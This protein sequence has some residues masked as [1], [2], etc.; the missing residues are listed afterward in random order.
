[1]LYWLRNV[2]DEVNRV[3]LS[4][5]T[6]NIDPSCVDG[7]R[8][9]LYASTMKIIFTVDTYT[10]FKSQYCLAHRFRHLQSLNV[11]FVFTQQY[12]GRDR[13]LQIL[14]DDGFRF[15]ILDTTVV[16]SLNSRSPRL[17]FRLVNRALPPVWPGLHIISL[18][19]K[20][21]SMLE[22]E[23]PDAVVLPAQNRF[24]QPLLASE[25]M[26][27]GVPVVVCPLWMAGP[28]EQFEALRSNAAQRLDKF[29]NRLVALLFPAWVSECH[30]SN[31]RFLALPWSEVLARQLLG[32]HVDRPWT[33]HSGDSDVICVESVRMRTLGLGSGLDASKLRIT[34][35]VFH[36]MMLESSPEFE[37]RRMLVSGKQFIEVLTALPPDMFSSRA[38]FCVDFSTYEDL[39]FNWLQTLQDQ[40]NTRAIVSLHPTAPFNPEWQ[41]RFPEFIWTLAPIESLLP[42]CDLFVAS[43]SATIQWARACGIPVINY[44]VYGYSYPDYLGDHYVRHCVDFIGYK[45]TLSETISSVHSGHLAVEK[46]L[47]W[48]VLDGHATERVLETLLEISR[49]T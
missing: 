45:S 32:V 2:R 24:D 48:G 41:R 46:D 1:M 44:D 38:E 40:P 21:R 11:I 3:R 47:D 5:Q 23:I 8:T 31:Y 10:Y 49:S 36:D 35:S 19:R 42:N 43:I 14:R 28:N 20:W 16:R 4:Q 34:G 27:G 39:V 17:F 7:A 30:G 13:H 18:R 12:P 37:S 33:L 15:E 25:A 22:M 9:H 6:G 26:R 29:M